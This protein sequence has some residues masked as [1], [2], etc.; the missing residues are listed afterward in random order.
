MTTYDAVAESLVL[1]ESEVWRRRGSVDEAELKHFLAGVCEALYPLHERGQ[2]HGGIAPS[3][4]RVNAEGEAHLA[5]ERLVLPD[6][7]GSAPL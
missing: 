1:E 5:D 7:L 6:A 3:Q 4:I 2:V